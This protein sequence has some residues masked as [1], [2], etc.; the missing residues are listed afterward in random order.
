MAKHGAS[1]D[2]LQSGDVAGKF[3]VGKSRNRHKSFDVQQSKMMSGPGSSVNLEGQPQNTAAADGAGLLSVSTNTANVTASRSH[4]DLSSSI[5][6]L[7]PRPSS[8]RLSSHADLRG[9]EPA[10]RRATRAVSAS[11]SVGSGLDDDDYIDPHRDVGIA[12]CIRNGYFSWLPR[13]N[14]EALMSDINFVADA[15]L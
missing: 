2:L 14:S 4:Q 7:S 9:L 8:S 13:A 11:S 15:G 10:Q 12:V 3:A 6:R 5:S 1:K